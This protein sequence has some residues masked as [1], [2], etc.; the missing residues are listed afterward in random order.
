MEPSA[1]RARTVTLALAGDVMTGRGIDQVLP[2]PGSPTL[3]EAHVHDAREYV[4]LAERAN[5]RVPAPVAPAYPWGD[6]LARMRS[7]EVDL[8][9]VNLETA[10]TASDRAWPGKG[11]HYRMHPANID[12]LAVARIDCAVLANNHVMDWGRR[13]LADTLHALGGAGI[14]SAGAGPD[15]AAAQ[16]PARLPLPG[17]GDLLVFG[18]ATESS[19]VPADWGAHAQRSGVALLPDLSD[20]TADA[21]ADTVARHRRPGELSLVSIHWGGN[22][23]PSVP[24]AHRRFARRL[25]D[26]GAA[27]LVHGHSAHH[28]MPFELHRGKLILHGCGDLL[29]DYEGLR[30]HP[31]LRSD[32]GC[33]FVVTLDADGGR[34]RRLEL[35]PWRLRRLRLEAG[36]AAIRAEAERLTGIATCV[37]FPAAA[38]R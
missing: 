18:V 25:V 10:V 37:E 3:H 11:V 27:D 5:G 9:I 12:C 14:R 2:H 38:G 32:L 21:L 16:A 13:G 26:L 7:P 34:L 15:A 36:D 35:H 29:N 30:L 20:A 8:R 1:W 33:L 23:V 19:G 22:W 31:G 4:R 17:R 28:P 24:P 6:A